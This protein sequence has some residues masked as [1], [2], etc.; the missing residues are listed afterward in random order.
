MSKI[1]GITYD[2]MRAGRG[3]QDFPTSQDCF[4]VSLLWYD[5]RQANG[6]HRQLGGILSDR[7][8]ITS[9]APDFSHGRETRGY[10]VLGFNLEEPNLEDRVIPWRTAV[11]ADERPVI[12]RSIPEAKKTFKIALVK[13]EKAITLGQKYGDYTFN[14]LPDINKEQEDSFA[15]LPEIPM[16]N[17]K[18]EAA[19]FILEKNKLQFAPMIALH[20]DY[21]RLVGPVKNE[22][23]FRFCA[24]Y[25][26]DGRRDCTYSLRA[27][28]SPIIHNNSFLG[29]NFYHKLGTDL[30]GNPKKTYDI[31]MAS[32]V[33]FY[34]NWINHVKDLLEKDD[35]KVRYSRLSPFVMFYGDESK[36]KVLGL[37]TFLGENFTITHYLPEKNTET[38]KVLPGIKQLNPPFDWSKGIAIKNVSN[39]PGKTQLAVVELENEIEDKRQ[40]KINLPT[41]LYPIYGSQCE[42]MTILDE[43]TKSDEH[44]YRNNFNFGNETKILHEVPVI[45]WNYRECKRY[46]R[47]LKKDQFCIRLDGDVVN[48][49]HCALITAGNPVICN[50]QVTGIVNNPEH[51]CKAEKPRICTNVFELLDWVLEKMRD[52]QLSKRI[53][54][55]MEEKKDQKMMMMKKKKKKKKNLKIKRTKPTWKTRATT[56]AGCILPLPAITDNDIFLSF[57]KEHLVLIRPLLRH[58]YFERWYSTYPVKTFRFDKR[59]TWCHRC[60]TAMHFQCPYGSHEDHCV[61]N[62]SIPISEPKPASVQTKPSLPTNFKAISSAT[63]DEQPCAILANGP[64]CTRTGVPSRVCIRFGS[65]AS[66]NRTVKAPVTPKSSAVTGSP[67]RLKATTIRPNR[68]FISSKSLAKA[69]TAIISLATEMEKEAGRDNPFSVGL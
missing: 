52:E 6:I 59:S 43:T 58:T 29:I 5:A 16:R 25:L 21:Y 33:N 49:N 54:I 23:A 30:C 24:L 35:K 61:R 20:S 37:M 51:P 46:V 66:F 65:K 41:T 64:A 4:V 7:I 56:F 11:S 28:G 34:A 27:E 67:A 22:I 15:T 53:N 36:K 26:K 69:K 17:A 13:L 45:L 62:F 60:T 1:N 18:Y 19:V 57:P 48:R 9:W 10:C 63:I 8:I 38:L 39:Y 32:R 40:F 14:K 68:C 12:I 2:D 3:I 47:G 50:G 55:D 42:I 31:L 44:T